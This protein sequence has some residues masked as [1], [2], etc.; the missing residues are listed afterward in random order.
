MTSQSSPTTKRTLFSPADER[1]SKPSPA[2]LQAMGEAL[3]PKTLSLIIL[4]TEKCNFRCTYC[5]E[6]FDIGKMSAE[7]VSAIKQLI[8]SRMGDLENLNLSWF[9]GE[10]LA[11]A[12]VVLDIAEYAAMRCKESNVKLSCVDITTNGALLDSN[13]LD[14]LIACGQNRFQ[15][16]L[17]GWKDG[18][19]ET[20]KGGNGGGTFDLVW[21][22]LLMLKA[23][24]YD[25]GVVIRIHLTNRNRESV[26]ELAQHVKHEFGADPRFSVFLKAIEN[27]GGPQSSSITPLKGSERNDYMAAL[28]TALAGMRGISSEELHKDSSYICYASKPNNLIIRANGRLAKCTVAF[29]DPKNDVGHIRPDG[30]LSIDN[31]K[32]GFWFRGLHTRD[33]DVLS[34]PV[35]VRPYESLPKQKVVNI[36]EIPV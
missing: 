17:D 24:T 7:T 32:L 35:W 14:R 8:D 13:L 15:I 23:S 4:P 5:Y 28:K 3:T 34:C 29:E 19:D 36:A 22:A 25:I 2:Q 27:L 18:H 33:A 31:S 21:N 6:S 20:R 26:L 11:A 1:T 30:T 16:S 10:P 12:D 9:G